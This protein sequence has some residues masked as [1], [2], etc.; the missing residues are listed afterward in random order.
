MRRRE[1]ISLVGGAAAAWPVVARAQLTARIPR[2]G[3]L[4]SFIP[5]EGRHLWEACRQGLRELGYIEGHNVVLEP[6]W[7]EGRHERLPAL[8]ADL[9]R[10]KVDVIVS[11]ATPASLAA[12]AATR[13]IPIVIV[14]VGAPIKSG[15]VAS[16]P[17]P[18]GNVTGLSLLTPELSGKR[19]ELL[20][21]VAHNLSR[22]AILMNPD[23]PVSKVFLEDTKVAA[24]RRK[25]EVQRLDARNPA[26][27][28]RAFEDAQGA[29][30]GAM[31]VFDDPVLWSH[32]PQIVALAATK[33][34]AVMYGLR[35]FVDDG[36]LMSYGPNRPDQYRRTAGYVDKILKGAKPADLPVEQ[37]TT[38]DL[39]INLKTAKA[40]GLTIP[41]TLLAIA[42]E[43]IE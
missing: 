30:A 11:A 15:L 17:R 13:T 29:H 36:G 37:P 41:P 24:R 26:E 23:N 40:L 1:F 4:F 28:E 3:Y 16:L 38:F 12:K 2:V 33:R 6:R 19:L 35:D 7:A 14:A 22:V 20:M 25:I 9:V 32:R 27:I 42:G 5:S 8:A 31:V 34:I 21:D 39:V 18:G 43:V 10:L